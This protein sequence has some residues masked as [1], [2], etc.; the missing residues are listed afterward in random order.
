MPTPVARTVEQSIA[1]AGVVA[2]WDLSNVP[3]LVE[4]GHRNETGA[5]CIDAEHLLSVT[6]S[7]GMH[8]V[9]GPVPR[10]AGRCSAARRGKRHTLALE[11]LHAALTER[12]VP[13]RPWVP[14]F[15][16]GLC[17][18][19]CA[20]RA[21]PLSRSGPRPNAPP[22]VGQLVQLHSLGC[23]AVVAVGPGWAPRRRR[24]ASQSWT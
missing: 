10:A 18:P 3:A 24:E 4:V 12:A 22:R 11:A 1:A 8:R 15:R 17:A 7:A 2:V 14:T 5:I 6:L 19:P 16:A 9:T 20:A 23:T 13:V 21:R